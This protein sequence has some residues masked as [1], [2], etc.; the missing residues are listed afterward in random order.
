MEKGK[1]P[2]CSVTTINEKAIGFV[3]EKLPDDNILLRSANLFKILGDPTRLKILASL[4]EAELC[5]CDLSS[6]VDVSVSAV[7]HQLK[8]LRD[9][10]LVKHRRDGKIVYYS[11]DDSHVANIL[12]ETIEHINE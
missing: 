11:L 10:R 5:V 4:S 1:I 3:A 8:T 2:V 9:M 6:L 12:S 7:S